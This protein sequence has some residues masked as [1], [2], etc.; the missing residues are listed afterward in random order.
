[1]GA[2][3]G[4]ISLGILD[5]VVIGALPLVLSLSEPLSHISASLG[6]FPDNQYL[7]RSKK[8]SENITIPGMSS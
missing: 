4:V 5:G 8:T 3:V 6:E 2:L 1:M 7:P